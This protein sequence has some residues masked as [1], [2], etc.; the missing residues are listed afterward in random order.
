M[1]KILYSFVWL[2]SSFVY[3]SYDNILDGPVIIS[4]SRHKARFEETRR[5]MTKAGFTNIQ[6]FEAVD[7]AM[8]PDFFYENFNIFDTNEPRRGCA[9]SHISLW[10]L[11]VADTSDKQTLFICEDDMLPHTDFSI[12]FPLYWNATPKNFDLIMVGNKMCSK[13]REE[14]LVVSVPTLATHAYIIT[15]KGAKILLDHYKQI[16]KGSSEGSYIID[17]FL[18]K[19]MQANKITYYCY[20]GKKFPDRVNSNKIRK[21]FADGICFQNLHFVSTIS[22]K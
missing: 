22:G 2:Y 21:N 11:L 17:V 16:P 15:K 4:L 6:R 7:G 12:L 14:D 20:H 19:M 1:K 9:A 5:L 3:C 18:R 10:H 13:V 8:Y